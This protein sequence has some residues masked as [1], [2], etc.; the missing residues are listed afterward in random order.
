MSGDVA[1]GVSN[2]KTGKAHRGAP[3]TPGKVAMKKGELR[4]E[5]WGNPIPG[6]EILPLGLREDALCAISKNIGSH[7]EVL[8]MA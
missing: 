7:S 5:I 3:G 1:L 6:K 2:R 8:T 4:L